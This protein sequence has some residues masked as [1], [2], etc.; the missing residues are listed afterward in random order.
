MRDGLPRGEAG[1][2]VSA[3]AMMISARVSGS[4]SRMVSGGGGVS[5]APATCGLAAG[6]GLALTGAAAATWA[7]APLADR[8]ARAR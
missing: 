4:S 3:V 1:A 5:G 8:S 6:C 2:T 7:D